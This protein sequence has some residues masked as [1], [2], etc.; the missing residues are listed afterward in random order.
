MGDAHWVFGYGSLVWRPGFRYLESAPACVHG[1]ARR[2]WQG[3]P[4]HRGVPHAP[5][6]VVTLVPVPDGACRGV[7]YRVPAEDWE[8][9]TRDLDEREIG[10]FDRHTLEVRVA[11]ARPARPALTWVAGEANPNYLGPAPVAEI[12]AQVRCSRGRSGTNTEY[13]LRLADW[14]R[15]NDAVDDHVF[16]VADLLSPDR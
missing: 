10:G 11:D 3:S 5:G 13:V 1:F 12:A 8:A 16:A 14:L 6:R 15:A 7:V 4:D 2:F 9:V